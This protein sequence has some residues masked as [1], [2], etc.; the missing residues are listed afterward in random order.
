MRVR[1]YA[2]TAQCGH[3]FS[4]TVDRP[5]SFKSLLL[6]VERAAPTAE[7]NGKK[8]GLIKSGAA[9]AAPAATAPTPLLI[10]ASYHP[11]ACMLQFVCLLLIAC[12]LACYHPWLIAACYHPWL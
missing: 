5:S 6:T 9:M 11:C 7:M 1:G 2:Y 12:Y 3:S 10:V 4:Y 8:F